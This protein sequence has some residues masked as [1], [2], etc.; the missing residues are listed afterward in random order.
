MVPNEG[1][2]LLGDESIFVLFY[3]WGT[4][5]MESDHNILQTE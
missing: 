2:Q 3:R 5:S 1:K 4:K